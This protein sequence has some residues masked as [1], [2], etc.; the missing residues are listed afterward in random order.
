MFVSS[1]KKNKK[2][3]S[4]KKMKVEIWSDVTCT[5]CY[6]AKRKLESALSQFKHNS[7]IEIVWR[8][9]ELAPGLKTDAAQHL[10]QFVAALRGISLE[11]ANVMAG[12]LTN[13]AKEVGLVYDLTN[14][15]PANSFN[16]HRLS[17]LA[18]EYQLQDQ[19]EERLFKAYFTEGKNIDDV[20]TLLQLAAEI[21]L[22]TTEVKTMLQGTHYASEVHQD[23]STA[24]EMGITSVPHFVFNGTITV[25][26]AQD[27]QVFL[28]TL[29]KAFAQWE[30]DSPTLPSASS[31]GPSCRTGEECK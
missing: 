10:P 1:T 26:G 29:E 6:T 15:I 9:F 21:G 18:K 13:A 28:Q 31:A 17:H 11:Q 5:F 16:A 20:P 19:M 23:I 12:Q 27:G 4:T 8:S 22:N 24:R 3:M 14:A 30:L 2:K 7:K 25:S